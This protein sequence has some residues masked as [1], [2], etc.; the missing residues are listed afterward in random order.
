MD[1]CLSLARPQY[2]SFVVLL[3]LGFSGSALADSSK[4]KSNPAPQARTS[5]TAP[6]LLE[7]F[8]RSGA[9]NNAD[10]QT[11]QKLIEGNKSGR[12]V[13]LYQPVLTKEF[14]SGGLIAQNAFARFNL[15]LSAP[16]NADLLKTYAAK[17]DAKKSLRSLATLDGIECAP[18][19]ASFNKALDKVRHDAKQSL[20]L[21]AWQR[22][23]KLKIRYQADFKYGFSEGGRLILFLV[24]NIAVAPQGPSL[25]VV[26]QTEDLGYFAHGHKGAS[27]RIF[28][29]DA[30]VMKRSRTEAT[31]LKAVLILQNNFNFQILGL[32]E[33]TVEKPSGSNL[34]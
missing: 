33:T 20:Q 7:Y 29:V 15:Y 2:L 19:P 16:Q 21:Q 13:F 8:D 27:E 3:L 34:F 12:F 26:V 22:R 18:D 28:A 1:R 6:V 30:S 5:L 14:G 17:P 10:I 32:A 11:F 31:P 24:D 4:D 23:D 9:V 25:P